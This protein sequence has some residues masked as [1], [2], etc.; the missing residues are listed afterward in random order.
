[1]GLKLAIDYRT[2]KNPF[3]V[4]EPGL[5]ARL[6]GKALAQQGRIDEIG[7]AKVRGMCF[8]VSYKW[9]VSTWKGAIFKAEAT[10]MLKTEAK[11]MDYLSK[12]DALNTG[13]YATWFA[14]SNSLSQTTLQAWGA[15][16][17]HSCD[18]PCVTA[19][20]GSADVL[21]NNPDT[22]MIV[23]FFGVTK[24]GR[25]W[26]HAT[27]YCCRANKPQFFDINY[28]VYDFEGND[29]RGTVMQDWINA[30]YVGASKQINDYVLYRIY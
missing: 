7:T 21:Q 16:H 29:N 4:D 15:K 1:M 10:N 3:N 8:R 24:V 9:L 25:V 30:R 5:H 11:Q 6:Q 23:G 19:D 13:D 12:A 18:T 27:A 20:M 22:A 26:G 14:G 28:G 2:M 17:G